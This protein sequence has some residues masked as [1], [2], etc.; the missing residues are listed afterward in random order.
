M[1]R[2]PLKK[3]DLNFNAN[4]I[5]NEWYN[6]QKF[7]DNDHEHYQQL[8]E[9]NPI[10]DRYSDIKPYKHNMIT[11]NNIQ[12]YINASPI[13]ITKDKYF[14]TTQGPKEETIEDFWRMI[15]EYNC[16]VIVM[17]CNILEGGREKCAKYWDKSFRM[18]NYIIEDVK[19]EK[20]NGF[21]IRHIKYINEK[22]EKKNV[23]QIHFTD[24][25]DKG[26][27]DV[28]GGK[29]FETF[30]QIMRKIDEFKGND[31]I[32]VHC[33]A[34]VGRTGTFIAMYFLEKEILKQINDKFDYIQF[35]IFNLVRKLKEMRLYLVQNQEQYIF[36]YQFVYYLLTT[37]NI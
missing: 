32:V 4:N 19:E 3:G 16:K 11:L 33:S 13:N 6:L 31:P 26:V 10:L 15:D 36:V 18:N 30:I 35:S 7:V 29:I 22:K 5:N 2:I 34:G 25:P 9:G 23:Q 1:Q 14:I 21:I 17:L 28:K 24:W 20:Q 27:P 8:N 12:G 37:Y